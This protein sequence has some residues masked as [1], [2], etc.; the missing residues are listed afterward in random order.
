M[1]KKESTSKLGK[2]KGLAIVWVDLNVRNT[3]NQFYVEAFLSEQNSHVRYFKQF[4][5]SEEATKYIMAQFGD[6]DL[7]L[8]SR[9]TIA[10]LLPKFAKLPPP[11]NKKFIVFT[12][13]P[14][15]CQSYKTNP[16][17][18]DIVKDP[19][20]VLSIMEKIY[21]SKPDLLE[22]LKETLEAELICPISRELMEDP[23]LAADG[24]T[25]DRASASETFTAVL[26]ITMT[27]S[28]S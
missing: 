17:V 16:L 3:E 15:Q 13:S 12:Y 14:A 27:S 18:L 20:D 7:V 26:P 2:K 25:Y 11:S 28:T 5:E 24:N 1:E 8:T 10:E 4:T 22:P 21:N 9:K 19:L 6:I 23:V